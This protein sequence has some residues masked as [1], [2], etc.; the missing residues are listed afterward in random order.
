MFT[1]STELAW[2]GHQAV[3]ARFFGISQVSAQLVADFRGHL[4]A[5][6]VQV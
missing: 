1:S 3:V 4:K 6:P 2:T 5:P